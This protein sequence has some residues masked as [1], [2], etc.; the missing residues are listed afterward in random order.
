M[1]VLD[2]AIREHLDLKRQR[3]VSDAE[4][5]RAEEE[6]LGPARRA[7]APS[8][9]DEEQGSDLYSEETRVVSPMEDVA[10]PPLSSDFEERTRIDPRALPEPTRAVHDIDED[11]LAPPPPVAR[12]EVD[13]EPAQPPEVEDE[14]PVDEPPIDE[15]PVDEPRVDEASDEPSG[16][17]PSGEEPG[18]QSRL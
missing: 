7:A 1:G 4:I 11:P 8:F 5:A 10:P 16:E 17:R 15:P 13:D 3:G 14:P 2:E 6:A 12:D 18:G 9:H